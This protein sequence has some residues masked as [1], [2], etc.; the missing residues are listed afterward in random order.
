MM[1]QHVLFRHH[2]RTLIT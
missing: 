1:S 2:R